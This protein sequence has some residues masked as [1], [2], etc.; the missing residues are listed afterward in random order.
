MLI[1]IIDLIK[2]SIDLYKKNLVLFFTYA[3]LIAAPTM[4]VG[5]LGGILATVFDWK[6]SSFVTMLYSIIFFALGIIAYFLSLWFS[7]AFIKIMADRYEGKDV[8][9]PKDVIASAKHLILPAFIASVL[10]AL[11]VLGGLILFII[12]G[13]IFSVWFAFALYSVALDGQKNTDALRFSKKLVQGRWWA[14]FLRIL[15]PALLFIFITGILQMPL[16]Y[17]T[18]YSNSALVVYLSLLL[19][20]IISIALSPLLAS[21]QT[22]LYLELKKTKP[23]NITL[24]PAEVAST[25]PP[26]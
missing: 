13:I 11:A 12:P 16:D 10:T 2:R 9:K 15:L 21:A 24:P 23:E 19:S 4:A 20:S 25:E 14:A 8:Q 18:N 17:L 7:L 5:L 3:V 1:S 6:I 22:I 26:A